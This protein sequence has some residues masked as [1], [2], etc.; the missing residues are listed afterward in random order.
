VLSPRQS[1]KIKKGDNTMEN[2]I[3]N[4]KERVKRKV[5]KTFSEIGKVG[6]RT[7]CEIMTGIVKSKDVKLSKIGRSLNEEIAIQY[8]IKRLSRN[9]V[10]NNYVDRINDVVVKEVFSDRQGDEDISIDISDIRK[11]YAKKMGSICKIYDG[12][13]KEIGKG[14]E[15]LL[16]SVGKGKKIIPTYIDTYSNKGMDYDTRW[17]KVK[18]I[19]DQLIKQKKSGKVI[20]TILLDRGFDSERTFKYLINNDLDFI[21]RMK[22]KRKIQIGKREMKVSEIYSHMSKQEHMSEVIHEEKKKNTKINIGYS[23]IKIDGIEKELTVVVVKSEYYPEPMYLLTSK[24]C[25]CS[26]SAK[27]IY[28]KYLRRWGIETLIR[29]LKEEYKIEDV[30]LLKYQSIRNIIS[31]AFFCLYLLSKIV[32]SIGHGTFF[33]NRY[34]AKIGKRIKKDGFFLYHAISEGLSIVL[35]SHKKKILFY[36]KIKMQELELFNPRFFG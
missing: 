28:E 4:F 21:V 36:P 27:K 14:Y 13:E 11:Y 1:K 35:S 24:K 34:L 26:E 7:I 10:K 16:C 30:R 18:K 6:K 5:E 8:T 29:T 19:F 23:K 25:S 3:Q 32:Y 9:I 33:L 20:G 22:G 17:H 31:L 15:M 2:I 12:S